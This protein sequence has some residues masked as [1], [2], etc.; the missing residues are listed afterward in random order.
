[1]ST[2]RSTPRLRLAHVLR[3]LLLIAS[4]S[5]ALPSAAF[6]QGTF[7]AV[8]DALAALK[9]FDLGSD[10]VSSIIDVAPS[11]S[12]ITR[13]DLYYHGSAPISGAVSDL[14]VLPVV[15]NGAY[16]C[17]LTEADGTA[18][19]STFAALGS[20]GVKSRFN[21]TRQ[22]PLKGRVEGERV[23]QIF[24]FGA[25]ATLERQDFV[26]ETLQEDGR[27]E[28]GGYL[29]LRA[30]D[31]DWDWTPPKLRVVVPAGPGAFEGSILFELHGRSSYKRT[32]NN[33]IATIVGSNRPKG[34]VRSPFDFDEWLACLNRPQAGCTTTFNPADP[35]G[36]SGDLCLATRDCGPSRFTPFG[37]YL[38]DVNTNRCSGLCD[39]LSDGVLPYSGAFGGAGGVPT[40]YIYMD[41]FRNWFHLGRT[42]HARKGNR[43]YRVADV[44]S[45]PSSSETLEPVAKLDASNFASLEDNATLWGRLILEAGY[46][47]A[48][49][50]ELETKVTTAL[51]VRDGIAIRQNERGDIDAGASGDLVSV[52]T[53]VDS[54]SALNIGVDV[55]VAFREPFFGQ[56]IRHTQRF[57]NLVNKDREPAP[58][59]GSDLSY[60]KE[61]PSS[62]FSYEVDGRL[63]PDAEGSRIQ[64]QFASE[65]PPRRSS[66]P[67]SHPGPFLKEVTK[68]AIDAIHPCDIRFC[69]NGQRHT[70]EWD[71]R[72]KRIVC[73]DPVP[74][75]GTLCED[76]FYLCGPDNKFITGTFTRFDRNEDEGADRCE[77]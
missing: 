57:P 21:V 65:R 22:D 4:A 28:V 74:G 38:R 7:A 25:S 13:E 71:A 67:I 41:P 48:D 23:G 50:F 54:E 34:A 75:C 44:D 11:C 58:S 37:K 66:T 76:G 12:L 49:L 32:R 40:S 47:V 36:P 55:T 53:A 16:F 45:Y 19:D 43:R 72:N 56:K 3:R 31:S 27:R 24:L 63:L 62:M 42:G 39:Q 64:C 14:F 70:C 10:A 2:R 8:C 77:R 69:V 1:M 51:A 20:F 61:N 30:A 29:R 59:V 6:A 33:R 68:R 60:R 18:S 26:L 15:T 73:Q 52:S 17:G 9:G 5:L 46:N 35:G